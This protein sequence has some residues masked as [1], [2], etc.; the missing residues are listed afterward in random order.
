[1]KRGIIM[2]KT[3]LV[4]ILVFIALL[5]GCKEEEY[6]DPLAPTYTLV[7]DPQMY[8]NSEFDVYDLFIDYRD[9]Y[10]EQDVVITSNY[11]SLTID[12]VG[13]YTV[14]VELEDTEG[15]IAKIDVLLDIVSTATDLESLLMN[16]DVY[17]LVEDNLTDLNGTYLMDE[18]TFEYFYDTDGLGNSYIYYYDDR[19]VYIEFIDAAIFPDAT[20]FEQ[21]A[22]YVSGEYS[23]LLTRRID[24]VFYPMFTIA[25]DYVVNVG[26]DSQGD[27]ILLDYY[28]EEGT[29][30][31]LGDV[32]L[33]Y[34][35]YI[36]QL[37]TNYKAA[38]LDAFN[39]MNE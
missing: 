9:N 17:Q 5:S 28:Y 14:K 12:T 20:G 27:T 16:F 24:F 31:P 33:I 11:S 8:L 15:H 34:E 10:G 18:V 1:M 26:S 35:V 25:S 38:V 2:K 21:V 29:G 23:D 32:E 19:F 13:E 3:Y 37:I 4:V 7:N 30:V 39:T 22:I 36:V 6:I